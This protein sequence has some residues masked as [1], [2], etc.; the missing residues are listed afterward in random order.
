MTTCGECG[1]EWDD[2]YIATVCC[3]FKFQ[4]A[5]GRCCQCPCGECDT[6][7]QM[8]EACGTEIDDTSQCWCTVGEAE[9]GQ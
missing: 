1:R 9:V 6:V 2:D 4:D 8:C 5:P 3:T 7:T